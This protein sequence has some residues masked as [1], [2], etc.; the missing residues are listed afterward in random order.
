M[1]A[2][3]CFVIQINILSPLKLLTTSKH[4]TLAVVPS[5]TETHTM[6]RPSF[7]ARQ[8]QRH[9]KARNKRNNA[10]KA[11]FSGAGNKSERIRE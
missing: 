2:F 10:P 3:L 11:D 7:P 5:S 9:M 1:L 4:I 8:W 6:L